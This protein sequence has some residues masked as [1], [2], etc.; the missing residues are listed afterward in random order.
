MRIFGI[1]T[2]GLS[3]VLF[4]ILRG[5]RRS[6]RRLEDRDKGYWKEFPAVRTRGSYR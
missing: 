3:V 4:G 5:S 1:L 2:V 6:S